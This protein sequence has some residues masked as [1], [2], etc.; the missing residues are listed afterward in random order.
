MCLFV[1]MPS[2]IKALRSTFAPNV[3]KCCTN[4][5]QEIEKRREREGELA[6]IYQQI[7]IHRLATSIIR[8]VLVVFD[9]QLKGTVFIPLF[10]QSSNIAWKIAMQARLETFSKCIRLTKGC[11]W[12]VGWD[13]T[14]L[15][16]KRSRLTESR[17]SQKNRDIKGSGRCTQQL[18]PHTHTHT[19]WQTVP[20]AL[21]T[22]R[23]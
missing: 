11:I 9:S 1:D 17:P 22:Y 20:H 12:F 15:T 7:W 18:L 3:S 10:Q 14:K 6:K 21:G 4:N 23:R 5:D 8:L 16:I 2:A 19:R 13:R